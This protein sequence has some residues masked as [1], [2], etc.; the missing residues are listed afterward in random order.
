MPESKTT[1]II[2]EWIDKKWK[3]LKKIIDK[4]LKTEQFYLYDE[5]V[6]TAPRW[7][8]KDNPNIE[9]LKLKHR[10]VEK[11]LSDKDIISKDFEKNLISDFKKISP[12]VWW[13]QN[14]IDKAFS[15]DNSGL[16]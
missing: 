5:A 8:K 6:K 7:Y 16:I 4:I 14:I 1:G 10:I 13:M 9:L 12:F 3:D 11:P 2:R 15:I